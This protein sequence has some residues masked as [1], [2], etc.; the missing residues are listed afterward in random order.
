MN[1]QISQKWRKQ[2]PR[3]DMMNNI[4]LSSKIKQDPY[5]FILLNISCSDTMIKIRNFKQ[6]SEICLQSSRKTC[7]FK[8]I[9]KKQKIRSQRKSEA[10]FRNLVKN[11]G[12]HIFLQPSKMLVLGAQEKTKKGFQKIGAKN[13]LFFHLLPVSSSGLHLFKNLLIYAWGK[14]GVLNR[15]KQLSTLYLIVF[16]LFGRSKNSSPHFRKKRKSALLGK[17]QII[18][19]L[20]DFNYYEKEITQEGGN[21]QG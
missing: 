20:I 9:S 6:N 7:I 15:M 8:K 12:W 19:K 1:F 10:Q 16:P 18:E 4:V 21:R 13:R 5:S 17:T 2:G 14:S 3:D 11:K